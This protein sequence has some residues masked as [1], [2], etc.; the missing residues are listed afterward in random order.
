MAERL[1]TW[2][3]R[4]ARRAAA[5]GRA[6]EGRPALGGVSNV[7]DVA[8]ASTLALLGFLM[9]PLPPVAVAGCCVTVGADRSEI[10]KFQAG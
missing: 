3:A 1:I 5:Y 9:A 6:A 8:I 2:L 4:R 7:A 10:E